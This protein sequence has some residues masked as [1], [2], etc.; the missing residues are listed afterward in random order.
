MN[1][2]MKKDKLLDA[3]VFRGATESISEHY[4]LET[5]LKVR[6]RWKKRLGSGRSVEVTGIEKLGKNIIN[7]IG[8]AFPR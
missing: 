5:N 8:N 7:R 6:G 2:F 1:Y 3:N 4:F